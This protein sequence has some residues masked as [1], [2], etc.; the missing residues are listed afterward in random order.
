MQF[1]DGELKMMRWL[2]EQHAGWRTTR[3]II[4]TGSILIIVCGIWVMFVN[5]FDLAIAIL[6]VLA[7]G[8]LSYTLGS[9]SG[10]PEISLLLKLLESQV[11]ETDKDNQA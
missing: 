8:G 1:N 2:R 10:R 11:A 4:L 6:L 7:A 9:W 3:A 5:G